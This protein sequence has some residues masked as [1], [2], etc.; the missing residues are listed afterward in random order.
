[1]GEANSPAWA[2]TAPGSNLAGDLEADAALDDG[3]PFPGPKPYRQD[4]KELFFGRGNEIDELTSL[5][6]ST[7][8]V[9]IYAPS[10]S[11]KSSLL[12]AGLVPGL[13]DLGCQI[14][15]TV[16]LGRIGIKPPDGE[17]DT[18]Q[19]NP[20]IKLVYDTVLPQDASRS[21]LPDRGD[22]DE[23]AAHL[24]R[25]GGESFTLLILDQF[26]ELFVNQ[27]LWQERGTFLAQLRRVL[28]ANPWLHAVLAIRS[29]YLANLLP[30]ERDMPG[31]MLIRYGLESL[32]ERAAREAIELAFR[33]TGHPLTATE[34]DLV[35]DRLLNLDAGVPGSPVRGQYVNLIQLQIFCRRLWSE[36][37]EA[38]SRTEAGASDDS[39]LLQESDVNLADYMQ[40]FVDDAVASVVAQTH[41]DGGIVRRWLE[42][43][44]TTPACLRAV[45]LADNEQTAG[46]PEEILLALEN[47]RLIQVEQ[48]NQSQWAEL[49]H[50]SMVAAVQASNEAWG[51]SRRRTRLWR[52]GVLAV[53][54]AVLLALIPLFVESTNQS[55]Y[56]TVT[57]LFTAKT[58]IIPVPGVSQ[59][60]VVE[61]GVSLSGNSGAGIALESKAVGEQQYKVL[62]STSLAANRDDPSGNPVDFALNI[63]RSTSYVVAIKSL[64][65]KSI[66]H[67]PQHY[68][69][70][71]QSAP[72]LLDLRKPGA[73]ATVSLNSTIDAV[74]LYP[75]QP[76]FLGLVGENVTM[77]DVAGVRTLFTD[78]DGIGNIVESPTGGYA[79]LSGYTDY[80]G[81]PDSTTEGLNEVEGE[82]LKPGPSLSIGAHVHIK[83]LFASIESVNVKQ[84]NAPFGVETSCK[85]GYESLSTL[86]DSND[87]P[88]ASTVKSIPEGSI[89]APS[90]HGSQYQ[91]ILLTDP[92][93]NTN[94]VDCQVAVRSF[95]R[96][97]ITTV[98]DRKIGIDAGSLFNAYPVRLS[99]DS[100][101]IVPSLNGAQAS[102]SCPS[103]QAAESGPQRLLAFVPANRDC[104]LSIAHASG[105]AS[106]SVSFELLIDPV[107]S[108]GG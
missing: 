47:A 56:T 36:K 8:A 108:G 17:T 73:G 54:V 93:G 75:N 42:D 31:R 2:P 18:P 46:L 92:A 63:A 22:F 107:S 67:T 105:Q 74:K 30:H 99:T 26:E 97:E 87:S 64:N 98:R 61:I 72:V 81:E 23:L 100:V 58:Q 5:V 70:T 39:Q 10:G 21:E 7:S 94:E 6:L 24:H 77:D 50:D 12:Q 13:E 80:G 34:L 68:S 88:V 43:R 28:D 52:T 65:W 19:Q 106:K 16:R 49:T 86:I 40:S 53:A 71:V 66:G 15:P 33:Q 41:C 1:M 85:S 9:L 59:G 48:R 83:G 57:G 79:V 82:L 37:A 32:G 78:S 38:G 14:L 27:A 76:V 103:S 51:R 84:G 3:N 4:Q 89:L 101:V 90:G 11:G 91:L 69:V 60:Q 44:L 25:Q 102:M 45:L 35:L 55:G 29:D 104:M 96:Q 95:A 62:E 20:F